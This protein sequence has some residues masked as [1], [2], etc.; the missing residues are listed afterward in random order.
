MTPT[1]RNLALVQSGGNSLSRHAAQGPA[2]NNRMGN[3]KGRREAGL[4][5]H[6]IQPGTG[7]SKLLPHQA[8]RWG[9]GNMQQNSGLG[10][11]PAEIE[12]LSGNAPYEYALARPESR[13]ARI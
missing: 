2:N 6:H 5:Y 4:P 13:A 10:P 3:E 8:S 12:R 7:L 11:F 9:H 1:C